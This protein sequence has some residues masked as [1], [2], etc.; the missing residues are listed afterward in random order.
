MPSNDPLGS[1][2]LATCELYEHLLQRIKAIG[3]FQIEIKKTSIHPTRKSAF[4]GV[5]PRKLFLMVTIKAKEPI[6]SGRVAKAEQ[7]SK[8][9]WHLD[10]W[11][12]TKEEID[13]DLLGWLKQAYELC[14]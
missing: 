7:V 9:R 6:D 13:A 12:A 2:A 3:P 5:H 1:V 10:V 14:G 4:A 8:G 11:V